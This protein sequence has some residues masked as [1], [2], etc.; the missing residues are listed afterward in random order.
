MKRH[1]HDQVNDFTRKLI[2]DPLS[3][4][5]FLHPVDLGNELANAQYRAIVGRPMDLTHVQTSLKDREY[6]FDGWCADVRAI[7]DNAITYNGS[8]S[9][10]TGVAQYF[11]AKLDKFVVHITRKSDAAYT[12]TL[13]TAFAAYLDILGRPPLGART[14]L[15]PV[16]NMGGAFEEHAL[17]LLAKKMNK[18][19][20]SG[21]DEVLDL[22]PDVAGNEDGDEQT[23][24]DVGVL[25]KEKVKELW[26]F[27]RRK[28]AEGNRL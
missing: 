23:E 2:S 6:S 9:Y 13:G 18:I 27:V 24:V 15:A 19:V 12:A 16:E 5:L 25:P 11:G 8:G 20:A 1:I 4:S 3:S 21:A 7:F 17:A 22:L 10:I 26:A 28:E 14:A